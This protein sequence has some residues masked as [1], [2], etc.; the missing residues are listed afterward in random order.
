MNLKNKVVQKCDIDR[1]KVLIKTAQ[2]ITYGYQNCT[3]NVTLPGIVFLIMYKKS[4]NLY[5]FKK[6]V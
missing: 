5:I 2:N 1:H 3:Q 6:R 4:Q